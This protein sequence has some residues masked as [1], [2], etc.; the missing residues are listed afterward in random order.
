MQRP[1]PTKQLILELTGENQGLISALH[2]GLNETPMHDLYP[3]LDLD[4]LVAFEA[5]SWK[6]REATRDLFEGPVHLLDIY[7][8]FSEVYKIGMPWLKKY[9][10]ISKEQEKLYRELNPFR[11]KDLK[12][13]LQN[14]NPEAVETL[15]EK[16]L[17]SANKYVF[18]SQYQREK[19]KQGG[20]NIG[21]RIMEFQPVYPKKETIVPN[22][23]KEISKMLSSYPTDY[24]INKPQLPLL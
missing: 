10:N 3:Y 14:V 16:L 9:S 13:R 19:M 1:K 6:S 21:I 24:N 5:S 2:H 18:E 12:A 23:A 22:F 4:E 7:Q 8:L 15:K 17:E 11:G 20:E